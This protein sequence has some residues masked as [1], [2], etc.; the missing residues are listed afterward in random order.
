MWKNIRFLQYLQWLVFHFVYLKSSELCTTKFLDCLWNM[1][2]ILIWLKSG[3]NYG[4]NNYHLLINPEEVNYLAVLFSRSNS[5]R[6]IFCGH[7][8][9]KLCMTTSSNVEKCI[10]RISKSVEKRDLEM[11]DNVLLETVPLWRVQRHKRS[12][13][14]SRP[15]TPTHFLKFFSYW[16]KFHS[17]PFS[18]CLETI[19]IVCF[20]RSG[21]KQEGFQIWKE[22]DLVSLKQCVS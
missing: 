12:A 2:Y 11:L 19:Q 5:L 14:L 6:F 10:E 4:V 9:Y 21:Y 8:N 17:V 16:S 15:S 13:H 1:W 7:I 22:K 20:Q 18:F 3:F